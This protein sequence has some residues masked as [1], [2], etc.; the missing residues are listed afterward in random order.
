MKKMII[1]LIVALLMLSVSVSAANFSDLANPQKQYYWKC[2]KD[3]SQGK[4][5]I[6]L[7]AEKKYSL[8]KDC[9]VNCISKASVYR[10]KQ[11]RVLPLKE[12]PK[13]S[14]QKDNSNPQNPAP[15]PSPAPQEPQNPAPQEPQNP[16]PQPNP[17]PQEPQNPPPQP[18]APQPSTFK[19]HHFN[20][21]DKDRT[22][23]VYE[24]SKCKAQS[25]PLLIMFHGLGGNAQSASSE[26]YGWKST[27]DFN[28][29]MVAFPESL[30]LQAKTVFGYTDPAG[31]HW[32]ITPVIFS[33]T[34]DVEFVDQMISA[35]DKEYDADESKIFATGHSYG[36]YFSYYLAF[37]LPNRIKAF[38]SHSAG[39]MTFN[40]FGTNFYWPAE[41]LEASKAGKK[42]GMIIYSDDDTTSPPA[43]SK[44]LGSAL[45]S[46]GHLAELIELNGMGHSWDKARNQNQWDFFVK[47]S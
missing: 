9:S 24:P 6:K 35:V 20:I 12:L 29:F 25:C 21:K 28:N 18:P 22:Y 45:V 32:D 30:E 33:Y 40:I 19:E 11:P 36:G 5:C 47:N 39:L 7:L 16:A 26:T 41:P 2:L 46:K 1:I 10:P 23:W 15:Q 3:S 42:A 44:N 37:A 34:Q 17:P 8:Y 4:S 13:D 27:A 14:H 43:N 31:K 38:G